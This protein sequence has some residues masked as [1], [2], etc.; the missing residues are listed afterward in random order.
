[1]RSSHTRTAGDGPGMAAVAG[2]RF[3]VT[4]PP[5]LTLQPSQPVSWHSLATAPPPRHGDLLRLDSVPSQE[6]SAVRIAVTGFV[7]A[8]FERAAVLSQVHAGIVGFKNANFVFID[9]PFLVERSFFDVATF[10]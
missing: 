4:V 5:I 10:Q 8:V 6:G 7:P 1:M 9:C 2:S 3:V